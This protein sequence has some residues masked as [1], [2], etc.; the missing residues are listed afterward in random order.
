MQR[1][2]TMQQFRVAQSAVSRDSRLKAKVAEA[3]SEQKRQVTKQKS[4]KT[5][6]ASLSQIKVPTTILEELLRLNPRPD[7]K[8]AVRDYDAEPIAR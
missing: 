8:I 5:I 7:G 3:A 4:L 2:K 6:A 1:H